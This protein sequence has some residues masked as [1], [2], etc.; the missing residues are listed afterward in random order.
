MRLLEVYLYFFYLNFPQLIACTIQ[1]NFENLV[2]EEINFLNLH[3]AIMGSDVILFGCS[4]SD[5]TEH[6]IEELLP[7]MNTERLIVDGRSGYAGL[8]NIVGSE[9]YISI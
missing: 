1:E 2:G 8:T 6:M 4:H 7:S 3:D 9:N 5:I